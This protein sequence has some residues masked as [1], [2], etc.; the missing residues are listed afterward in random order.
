MS[1]PDTKLLDFFYRVIASVV[2]ARSTNAINKKNHETVLKCLLALEMHRLKDISEILKRN[3]ASKGISSEG[4]VKSNEHDFF[5]AIMTYTLSESMYVHISRNVLSQ[6]SRRLSK[7]IISFFNK[8]KNK[9]LARVLISE[10]GLQKVAEIAGASKR[11]FRTFTSAQ[12]S[13]NITRVQGDIMDPGESK[14]NS[15]NTT[16]NYHSKVH[17]ANRGQSVALRF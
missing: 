10:M 6:Y 4:L 1:Y 12:I 14:S 5:N 7:M 3:L 2:G 15:H 13:R 16:F 17:I 9:Y 8:Y 11:I